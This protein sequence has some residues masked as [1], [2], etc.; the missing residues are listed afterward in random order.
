MQRKII[1]Y[2]S[3][4]T[5]GIRAIKFIN[6][7][8]RK[9]GVMIKGFGM[10]GHNMRG[11]NVIEERWFVIEGRALGLSQQLDESG[12]DGVK[13]THEFVKFIPDLLL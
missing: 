8:S 3:D 9:T 5:H 10:K 6:L 11:F 4:P 13:F 12:F 2:L 1:L 7:N